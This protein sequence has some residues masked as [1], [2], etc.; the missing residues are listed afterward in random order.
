MANGLR[1]H[2]LELESLRRRAQAAK[3][4]R[5]IKADERCGADPL[6]WLQNHTK[7]RDDHWRDKGTEPF[8]RFPEKP[9]F[10]FIFDCLRREKRILIPKSRQ[11]ML[12]W[13]VVGYLVWTCQW[14]GP[15]HCIIQAQREDKA[16]DL[17][18]GVDVP[19]YARTLYEQ[20]DPFLKTL[21]PSSRAPESMAGLSFTWKNGSKIQ[22]LPAGAEQIRQYHPT[23]VFF[24]EAAFLENWQG[25]Y[26]AADPVT[27]QI[28]SVSS[29]APSAFGDLVQEILENPRGKDPSG[30]RGS[31]VL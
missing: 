4:L 22:G 21:H 2:N 24:D 15:A 8:A 1:N 23:I 18:G 31:G 17:V 19:G 12:S 3:I 13:I 11:M 16:H 14:Y 27:S 10:Q 7:T 30:T 5:E 26:E 29:A 28:I 25:S 6:Y 20:Q 9:Y